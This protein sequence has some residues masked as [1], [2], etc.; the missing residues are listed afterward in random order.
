MSAPIFR[1]L[2]NLK[3]I[4]A[5]PFMARAACRHALASGELRGLQLSFVRWL[6]RNV[7]PRYRD[8]DEF[9]QQIDVWSLEIANAY[10]HTRGMKFSTYLFDR[11][12]DDCK[13]L[14]DKLHVRSCTSLDA[15]IL[16]AEEHE[17]APISATSCDLEARAALKKL[18]GALPDDARQTFADL[19]SSGMLG[20]FQLKHF[21]KFAGQHGI[22][23]QKLDKLCNT[24][25]KLIPQYIPGIDQQRTRKLTEP[26]R[27]KL[28]QAMKY[29]RQKRDAA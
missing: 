11:L 7:P 14:A 22:N 25:D 6:L 1:R 13:T 9:K 28:S 26:A 12:R 4:H 21:R 15:A 8:R 10:D 20:E 27:Q 19:A 5:I 24:L 18:L 29:Q 3:L 16:D 17:Q 2:Q 23:K